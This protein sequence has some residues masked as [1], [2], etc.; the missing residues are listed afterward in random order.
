MSRGRHLLAGTFGRLSGQRWLLLGIIALGALLRFTELGLIRH[1]FDD[2]YPVYDALRMLATGRPLLVGMPS[3]V[4][5]DN[6]PLMSYLQAIPLVIW[7]SPWS[8]YLFVVALNTLAIWL[9]YRAVRPVLG[10]SAGLLAGALFALNPWIVFFSRRA[11]VQGLV[12]FFAALTAW[13]LLP[14]LTEPSVRR[15]ELRFAAGIAAATAMTLT[16]IQAGLIWATIALFTL[17]ARRLLTRRSLAVGL[18]IVVLGIAPFGWGLAGR[19]DANVAKLEGFGGGE[20]RVSG[21]A[22][23][24]AIR[25]VTGRDYDIAH[26]SGANGAFGARRALGLGLHY[27]LLAGLAM[28]ILRAALALRRPGP[29]RS[30]GAVLLIWFSVPVL[31]MTVSP[32]DVHPHYLLITLPAG[33]ALA[34]WGAMPLLTRRRARWG[35]AGLVLCMA[36]LT[37]ANL[38]AANALVA[39]QPTG[40]LPGEIALED[41]VRVGQTMRALAGGARPSAQRIV[42]PGHE[43]IYSS[44]A[45]MWVE[46]IP[47][48]A[49]PD[50]VVLPGQEPLIY[51]LTNVERLDGALGPLAVH[52]P[53][54]DLA[55][56]DGTVLGFVRVLPYS[57]EIALTLPSVAVDWPSAAGLSLLG[58]TL[59]PGEPVGGALAVTTFWRVDDLLPERWGWYVAAFYHLLDEAG[60]QRANQSGR[61]QWAQEWRQGDIHVER[62]Q[63][64]LPDGLAPGSY[65]LRVGLFNPIHGE[66]HGLRGPDGWVYALDVPVTLGGA[67]GAEP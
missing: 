65:T 49:F 58:Y 43:A 63:I 30:L 33:Q 6:P 28:G 67:L 8:V 44:L 45:G 25:L 47:D 20:V 54:N 1:T 17:S 5:L 39:R 32:Q 19:W 29:H 26:A 10:V 23:G 9:T 36:L 62:V 42:A 14:I 7:R 13:C 57:R 18:A 4:F 3:S 38:R 53:Q 60:E 35:V 56:A 51:V 34:T 64:P 48:L 15:R 22:L 24:H 46:S 31:L 27:V 21:A 55:L 61:G 37:A 16:Y 41:G 50:Y 11:W 40:Y 12:P 59:G 66:N 52:D 2:S